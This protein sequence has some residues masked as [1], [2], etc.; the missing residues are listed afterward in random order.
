[1]ASFVFQVLKWTEHFSISRY[2]EEYKSPE[3]PCKSKRGDPVSTASLTSPTDPTYA[4]TF[5]TVLI[6]D[7]R[8]EVPS[9][10][11]FI[12]CS[13]WLPP[14][15]A[16]G[17]D[18]EEKGSR[19]LRNTGTFVSRL[20]GKITVFKASNPTHAV[21]CLIQHVRQ[22]LNI[23]KSIKMFTPTDAQVFKRSIKIYIKTAQTYFGVITII[24]ERTIWAR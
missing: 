9:Q 18:V 20:R 3:W 14:H 24:R 4:G 5:L 17:Y 13:S 19:L 2:D 15:R 8:F 6:T 10:G 7:V 1:M 12:Y 22:S 16:I 21:C 23:F 11:R